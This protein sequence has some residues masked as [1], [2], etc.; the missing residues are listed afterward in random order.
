MSV[1]VA[2]QD[3]KNLVW[4]VGFNAGTVSGSVVGKVGINM[5]K[6]DHWLL[7][8]TGDHKL[9]VILEEAAEDK[10]FLREYHGDGKI[11]PYSIKQVRKELTRLF[12]EE[13]MFRTGQEGDKEIAGSVLAVSKDGQAYDFDSLMG[14]TKI[15]DYWAM[16]SGREIALGALHVL[17][18]IEKDTD[19]A[20]VVKP[21]TQ[22][23]LAV[24]ASIE[25]NLYCPGEPI[26]QRW[27]D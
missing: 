1:V 23:E 26:I 13:G 18:A 2:V 10:N 17:S 11:T 8:T 6:T 20:V 3:K 24:R 14:Y 7:V 12:E 19:G 4:W 9:Q 5:T 21:D 15:E 27:P 16:G 22:A 25:H